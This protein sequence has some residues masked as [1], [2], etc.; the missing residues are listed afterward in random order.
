MKMKSHIT[1]LSLK[2][3]L[4]YAFESH[5]LSHQHFERYVMQIKVKWQHM[6]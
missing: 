1:N 6:H 2:S 5:L 3:N 4:K